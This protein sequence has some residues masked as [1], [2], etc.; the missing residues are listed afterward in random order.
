M[1]LSP[2]EIENIKREYMLY[3]HIGHAPQQM[4]WSGSAQTAEKTAFVKMISE[5]HKRKSIL[6]AILKAHDRKRE[7]GT[8][9]QMESIK[10]GARMNELLKE[11]QKSD[12]YFSSLSSNM[13][14]SFE[15]NMSKTPEFQNCEMLYTY[16]ISSLKVQKLHSETIENMRA[17]GTLAD[18]LDVA[19][20]DEKLKLA[21]QIGFDVVDVKKC[22]KQIE[23]ME[24]QVETLEDKRQILI[25]ERKKVKDMNNVNNVNT[26]KSLHLAIFSTFQL[27]DEKR[28]EKA[29]LEKKLLSIEARIE[30]A[31][32][33]VY[34][35]CDGKEK[36]SLE[37]IIGHSVK[38]FENNDTLN[39]E[40]KQVFRELK[41]KAKVWIR[42][43][44]LH[45]D[46]KSNS[47]EFNLMMRAVGKFA[48]TDADNFTE[49]KS[50]V[51][52]MHAA[53]KDY[54]EAKNRQVRLFSSDKRKNP[55]DTRQLN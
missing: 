50:I 42:V 27:A 53:S 35:G 15:K 9:L 36:A 51:T 3:Q 32:K 11:L 18:S 45:G 43:A 19:G 12:K 48:S 54:L 31:G 39:E 49:M 6:S 25:G 7:F 52:A 40:M 20:K 23:N 37:K 47:I 10:A 17:W 8:E 29:K 14:Y 30:K 46:D 1:L 2:M 41:D 16:L 33:E 44:K 28:K 26:K 38:F 21:L 13:D 4:E 55:Y 22:K 5:I 34:E 24:Q